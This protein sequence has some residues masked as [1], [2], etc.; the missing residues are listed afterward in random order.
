M[1]SFKI[2]F[3]LMFF[4]NFSF[5]ACGESPCENAPDEDSAAYC[6]N[7]LY[8]GLAHCSEVIEN[9]NL[10]SDEKYLFYKNEVFTRGYVNNAF[11]YLHGGGK[12]MPDKICYKKNYDGNSE[13]YFSNGVFSSCSYKTS[14]PCGEYNSADYNLFATCKENE[15][16]NPLK[17]KCEINLCVSGG[18]GSFKRVV[19]LL[20]SSDTYSVI[21][22]DPNSP[23][24]NCYDASNKKTYCD[25]KYSCVLE[26][27]T[28]S[29]SIA[30]KDICAP[31]YSY[32]TPNKP[33]KPDSGGDSGKGGDDGKG[34]DGGKGGDSGKGGDDGK[35]GDSGKGGD[36]GKGGDGGDGGDNSDPNV[37]PVPNP[38]NNS[39]GNNLDNKNLKDIK[40]LLDDL[41]DSEDY[42]DFDKKD[43]DLDLKNSEDLLKQSSDALK[44]IS[45]VMGNTIKD[46]KNQVGNIKK[47]IDNAISKLKD[48]LGG[49]ISSY[50]TC[51]CLYSKPLNLGFKT[52]SIQMDPCE[53][54]CKIN[55]VT[56]LV[57]FIIFFY[58]FLKFT[59]FLLFKIF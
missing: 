3:I 27:D 24:L 52:I 30:D 17:G 7:N 56:Y 48:P 49:S 19:N 22:N 18:F 55:N 5:G 45:D 34:G 59:I 39:S 33:D 12:K 4:I 13:C 35:G 38:D 47:S 1:K 21:V 2:L 41:L 26:C 54:I 43:L 42:K 28:G 23:A 6:A 46:T 53:F 8:E 40:D 36:D 37:P 58:I 9:P 29:I 50:K 15:V 44:N 11:G 10:S 20:N 31:Y 14:V 25:D 51:N 32:N 16:F 57:F